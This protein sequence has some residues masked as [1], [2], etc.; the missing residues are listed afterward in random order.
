MENRRRVLARIFKYLK[1]YWISLM[2]G[3][4]FVICSR[5]L[6]AYIPQHVSNLVDSIISELAQETRNIEAMKD[7][8]FHFLGIYIGLTLMSACF[9]F[10]MRQTIILNS[11]K[12][13]YGYKNELYDHIQRLK[14]DSFHKYKVGD[15]MSRIAE[16]ISRIRELFGPA[17]MYFVLLI[18]TLT[19][20]VYFMYGVSPSLTFYTIIPLP[21]MSIFVYIINQR[22]Y[23]YTKGFQE[24]QSMITSL[25]QES[26]N[27]I[28]VIK[29]YLLENFLKEKFNKNSKE[30]YDKSMKIVI[31]DSFFFPIITVLISISILTAIFK[32]GEMYMAGTISLGNITEFV[33][34]V[35]ALTWPVWSIGWVASLY[36][37]GRAALERYEEIMLM[38][39]EESLDQEEDEL[40]GDIRFENVSFRYQNTGIEAL[41]NVSFTIPEGEKWLVVG[42]TGCGKTT[43]A[44]LLLKY[45]TDYTGSISIGNQT[46][47]DVSIHSLRNQ[48]SYIPQ[49]V[50]LFSDTVEK[51]I[52]FSDN[53]ISL[54]RVKEV[55]KMAQIDKEIQGF[56]DGYQT[57]VGEKGVTLSGGQ[58]QRTSIARALVKESSIFLFDD[59][60]SAVDVET[61]RNLVNAIE[62]TAEGSTLILITHRIYNQLNFDKVLVL[63]DGELS[64]IGT[65]DEL[66]NQK[67]K[68]YE[69]YKKQELKVNKT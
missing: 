7:L 33:M 65:H 60:L 29:S 53:D 45:Y 30:L 8:L 66:Y 38:E 17:L 63:H 67:G 4:L 31:L 39:Q 56:E 42:K 68:Y 59:C 3:I 20:T 69:L 11:R 16:D 14:I 35:Q 41:K 37:R 43:I 50:F 48:I 9:T 57:M 13:E 2:L 54:E 36:Q 23:K 19:I 52:S 18:T 58:K 55:A 32:G 34:Y 21:L 27:G 6:S 26:Y 22:V 64:E 51:N 44:E 61:E 12:I 28:R 47:K 24:S 25:A 15:Y 10:L 46:L 40:K 1:K 49:E 5:L 62:R